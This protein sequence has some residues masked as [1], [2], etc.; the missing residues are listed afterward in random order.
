MM[1]LLAVGTWVASRCSASDRS[2]RHPAYAP[3]GSIAAAAIPQ[4]EE[5]GPEESAPS[6]RFVNICHLPQEDDVTSSE[7][8]PLTAMHPH[9]HAPAC[10]VHDHVVL[11]NRAAPA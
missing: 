1:V 2:L 11:T 7:G 9:G 5:A 8:I 3:P 6:G 4:A 10:G